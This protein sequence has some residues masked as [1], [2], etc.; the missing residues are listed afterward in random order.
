M[1]EGRSERSGSASSPWHDS[2]DGLLHFWLVLN[3]FNYFTEIEEHFQRR[4]G[5]T[6]LLSTLDWALI[7]TWK[8]T[9]I[10]LEAV[11]RGIDVAFE[12]F[13]K[14]PLLFRKVNSLAYCSQAVLEAAEQM[15]EAEVGG[16]N[17][18][19][20]QAKAEAA[21]LDHGSVALYLKQTQSVLCEKAVHAGDVQ[22]A[23]VLRLACESLAE[24]AARI[25]S[26]SATNLE[27]VERRLTV[28]EEKIH[29]A[30]I[31]SASEAQLLEL[32]AQADHDLA[33]YRRQMTSPQIEQLHRQ[34]IKKHLLERYGLP[35]LS[36]FYM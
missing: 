32:R 3:Y 18:A 25:E 34:Y 7:E 22:I 4:R 21:G 30:L 8:D 20:T 11:L 35:R 12:K 33:P 1:S 29:A 24:M 36:L 16:T 31:A 10:P 15:K 2:L 28:L 17:V 5:T 9:G 23:D 14:R 26:G 27:D 6:L 13:H 19:N